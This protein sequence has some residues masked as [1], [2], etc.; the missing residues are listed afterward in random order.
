[1]QQLEIELRLAKQELA[2]YADSDP[3]KLEAMSE[4]AHPRVLHLRCICQFQ[5]QPTRLRPSIC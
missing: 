3:Q 1:M 2:Q 5:R 4:R